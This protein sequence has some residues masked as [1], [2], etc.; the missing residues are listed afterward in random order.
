MVLTPTDYAVLTIAAGGAAIGLFLGLSGAAAFL[1]GTAVSVCCAIFGWSLLGEYVTTPWMRVLAMVIGVLL[2][3]GLAR[4]LVRRFIHVMIAQPGDAIF[5][6]L[7]LG[8][9]GA[10]AALGAVW[11]GRYLQILPY[12]SALLDGVLGY[13]G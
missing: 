3:F 6:A 12:P 5:G 11:L 2:A 9:V 7:T 1:A 10:A 8:A 13:V 4:F